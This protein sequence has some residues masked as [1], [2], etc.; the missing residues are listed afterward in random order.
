MYPD[1]PC[2]CLPPNLSWSEQ[3][4]GGSERIGENLGADPTLWSAWSMKTRHDDKAGTPT[5]HCAVSRRALQQGDEREDGTRSARDAGSERIPCSP[6]GGEGAKDRNAKPYNLG[7]GFSAP[8]PA[9]IL[10]EN[11]TAG[12]RLCGVGLGK[13]LGAGCDG[14][15]AAALRLRDLAAAVEAASYHVSTCYAHTHITM[16]VCIYTYVYIYIYI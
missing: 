1:I 10:P 3:V 9:P 15:E 5:R 16:Y 14:C 4:L 12:Q 8:L 11:E 13:G 7:Y 6:C 2:L